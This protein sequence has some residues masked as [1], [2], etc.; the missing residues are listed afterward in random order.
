M[1]GRILLPTGV[2][3]FT[4]PK[5][6]GY[7]DLIPISTSGLRLERPLERVDVRR[8]VNMVYIFRGGSVSTI[9]IFL[10][11]SQKTGFYSSF[12]SL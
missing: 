12:D 1:K 6:N 7:L 3:R 5:E 2:P 10:K 11:Q 9:P 4:I 8:R